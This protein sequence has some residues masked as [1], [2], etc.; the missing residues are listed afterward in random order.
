MSCSEYRLLIAIAIITLSTNSALSQDPERPLVIVP[1]ILG[2]VLSENGEIAWG[3]SRSLKRDNIS[4]LNLLSDSEADLRATDIVRHVPLLFGWINVPVYSALIQFLSDSLG[5]QEGANLH[6][7]YYDW[8]RTNFATAK[9]LSEFIQHHVGD[10]QFDLIA[11][12]MGGLV[13]RIMLAGGTSNGVCEGVA[14]QNPLL[15]NISDHDLSEVCSAMYG[16][17]VS[18]RQRAGSWPSRDFSGPYNVS[19]RLHTYIEIAVPHFGSND[20]IANYFGEAWG[21]LIGQSMGEQEL[22]NI[23]T[24]MPSFVELLPTYSRCCVAGSYRARNNVPLTETEIL[25]FDWWYDE[26]LDMAADPCKYSK[27][28]TRRRM[29]AASLEMRQSIYEIVRKGIPDTV[30]LKTFIG[31]G[32]H[33]TRLVSY[34]NHESRS[35]KITFQH[36]SDGDGS[37]P[38][39]SAS[40][41]D[42]HAHNV[43][44]SGT[45]HAF[46]F[47]NELL[48]DQL[49]HVILRPKDLW[50]I[51]ADEQQAVL[52]GA[53]IAA[54]SLSLSPHIALPRD[55]IKVKVKITGSGP[56]DRVAATSLRVTASVKGSHDELLAFSE[57]LKLDETSTDESNTIVFLGAFTA[58]NRPDA[59]IATATAE[60]RQG[61]LVIDRAL[62]F[63]ID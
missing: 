27:C 54:V 56:F 8:R 62:L 45:R 13:S 12:S 47:D 22:S 16:S 23:L 37:V 53:N 36:T 29:L 21:R 60:N 24:S 6:V 32:I 9:H 51:N 57:S 3:S 33:G 14:S 61:N 58:P 43:V 7:F 28:D 11:H 18:R 15:S 48:K 38:L 19:D 40:S 42:S 41:P 44:V 17:L 49:K 59:Y 26:I 1:G 34:F 20:V 35:S 52:A 10:Q 30:V 5:Y 55:T 50:R 4:R 46:L 25:S 63:V 39:V 2:S 31:K